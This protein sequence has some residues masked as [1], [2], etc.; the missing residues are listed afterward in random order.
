MCVNNA[1]VQLCYLVRVSVVQYECT[2]M[3]FNII[4]F[5]S[6][7]FRGGNTIMSDPFL[8]ARVCM[9]LW[10]RVSKSMRARVC[11]NIAFCSKC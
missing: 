9:S 3:L 1:F 2:C 8:R 4:I 6:S 5:F 11:V 10:L 7:K